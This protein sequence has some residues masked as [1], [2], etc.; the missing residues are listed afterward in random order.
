M[1]EHIV[2]KK[3]FQEVLETSAFAKTEHFVLHVKKPNLVDANIDTMHLKVGVVVPKRWAKKAVSRNTI[4]RQIYIVTTQESSKYPFEK[5]VVRLN[6]P[7]SRSA[8]LSPSSRAL[9]HAVRKEILS[10]YGCGP[11]DDF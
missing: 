5:H 11:V 10:L 9:K 8:F 3:I 2:D 1:I 4:K 7:F 6:R